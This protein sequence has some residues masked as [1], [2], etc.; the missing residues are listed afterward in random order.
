M[1]H[2]SA[3]HAG[4]RVHDAVDHERRHLHVV[5]GPRAV[6]VGLEPPRDAQ[7]LRVVFVDLVERGVFRAARLAGI[8][9]PFA[10][11]RPVLGRERA[12]RQR[13]ANLR[14]QGTCA[15]WILRVSVSGLYGG[16]GSSVHR[17]G[18]VPMDRTSELR[19]SALG[20]RSRLRK[21]EREEFRR[22]P[23]RGHGDDDV[24]LAVRHVGHRHVR[25][26]RRNLHLRHDR[27]GRF[28]IGA[29]PRHRS[30]R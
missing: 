28:V 29:E 6:V 3:P 27:A 25:D 16:S 7:V 26:V 9:P 22:L 11:R 13:R 17:C 14:A 20:P 19:T 10:V 1:R 2:D 18:R 30:G 12:R 8:R 5:V 23:D 24:L 21:R 15:P 4:L